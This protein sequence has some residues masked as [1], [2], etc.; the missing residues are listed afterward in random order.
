MKQGLSGALLLIVLM[1]A[2]AKPARAETVWAITEP[3]QVGFTARQA[4]QPITGVFRTFS[5]KIV[6]SDQTLDQNRVD[7]SIDLRSVDTGNQDRDDTLRSADFFDA[8]RTPLAR[9]SARKFRRVD[10]D[11]YT[12]LGQLTIRDQTRDAALAF[13]LEV[14]PDLAPGR[15]IAKVKGSLTISRTDFGIGQGTWMDSAIVAD[16]V[17]IAIDIT[18]GAS[19]PRWRQRLSD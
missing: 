14:I 16:A 15:L 4:G 3:S 7:V 1:L 10:G 8:A 12:A 9:F 11:S 2:I 13:T 5:A 19:D 6:F 18:A 17:E